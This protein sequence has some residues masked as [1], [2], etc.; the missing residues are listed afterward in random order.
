[1]RGRPLTMA[2]G[3]RYTSMLGR[4]RSLKPLL[5]QL[6]NDGVRNVRTTRFIQGRT[7]RWA[8]A[9]TFSTDGIEKLGSAETCV[10]GRRKRRRQQVSAVHSFDV[11]S[12]AAASSSPELLRRA[13]D[14]FTWYP[15][16]LISSAEPE[17]DT[18]DAD[19]ALSGA[20][21]ARR[22]RTSEAVNADSA[23]LE[24]IVPAETL[25]EVGSGASDAERP[26]GRFSFQ[27]RATRPADGVCRVSLEF[28][29]GSDRAAFQSMCDCISG[30]LARTNRRWRRKLRTQ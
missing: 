15:P 19:W 30:E 28:T 16:L 22:S 25:S 11:P 17:T 29:G 21:I 6:R 26:D 24:D 20:A 14:F 2:F 1:M 18:D 23:L 7:R 13:R 27:L 3:I 4:R 10:F 5:R 9:W 8:L 12:D